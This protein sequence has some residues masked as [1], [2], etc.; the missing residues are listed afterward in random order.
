MDRGTYSQSI[1]QA[2][3]PIRVEAVMRCMRAI[4]AGTVAAL[5]SSASVAA[6][7]A[8]LLKQAQEIFRPLLK[9]ESASETWEAK[10]RIALG[11]RL[12]FDPRITVDG[13]VS[14][15]TCHQPALYGVDGLSKSIGVQQRPASAQRAD[16]PEFGCQHHRPLAGRSRE[17]SRT[18]PS[19]HWDLRSPMVSLT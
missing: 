8:S 13:N 12:F 19:R 15:A 3:R 7:D 14:C 6:D 9:H 10:E 5:A 16:R 18:R 2:G 1:R 4:V 11:R 17:F